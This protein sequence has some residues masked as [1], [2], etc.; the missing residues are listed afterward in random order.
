MF[1]FANCFPALKTPERCL[2][3]GVGDSCRHVEM[4]LAIFASNSRGAW[5]ASLQVRRRPELTLSGRG[6]S[7]CWAQ[8]TRHPKCVGI[9]K[10]NP[11]SPTGGSGFP[12]VLSSAGCP[13]LSGLVL[14]SGPMG[15]G[16]ARSLLMSPSFQSAVSEYEAPL[17]CP[18]WG[19]SPGLVT[20]HGSYLL[21]HSPEA[22]LP[23]SGVEAESPRFLQFRSHEN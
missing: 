20:P 12:E 22:C 11:L 1:I 3:G 16:G 14:G 17:P 13:V 21:P 8:W 19:S 2:S 23:G 7:G 18:L 5:A 15:G 4:E 9:T 10:N 6:G